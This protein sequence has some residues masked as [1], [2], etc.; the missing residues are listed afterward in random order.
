MSE[1]QLYLP[2][3]GAAVAASFIG[4]HVLAGWA[5]IAL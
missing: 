4:L 1:E 5:G 2:V 3:C